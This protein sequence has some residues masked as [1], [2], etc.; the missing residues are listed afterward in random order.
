MTRKITWTRDYEGEREE[1]RPFYTATV[2]TGLDARIHSFPYWTGDCRR[3]RIS[4]W[5]LK[6]GNIAIEFPVEHHGRK[7]RTALQNA[8]AVR[9]ALAQA[10][11]IAEQTR[12]RGEW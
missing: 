10:K 12:W 4:A 5:I 1:R 7:G 3:A 11:R 8:N 9:T 2:T 6:V